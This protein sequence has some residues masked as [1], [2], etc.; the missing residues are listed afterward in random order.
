M[1][2]LIRILAAAIFI[3]F[4]PVAP[5]SGQT[6][7]TNATAVEIAQ[8]PTFC[9][10]QFGVPNTDGDQFRM[11]ACGPGANHYCGAL[12]QLIR[13]KHAPNKSARLDLVG[14]ADADVAYTERAIKDYP[15][16]SIR[17]HVA[18][19]RAEVNSLLIIYGGKRVRA[20]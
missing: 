9:W 18:G 3:S 20:Q 19:T 13:A 10:A 1:S 11:Q 7:S 12:I 8:L 14:H 4:L 17:E 5:A 15:Q 2:A 6:A 16:C